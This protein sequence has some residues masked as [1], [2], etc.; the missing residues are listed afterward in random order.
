MEKGYAA[1]LFLVLS[2]VLFSLGFGSQAFAEE[3]FPMGVV[4][5]TLRARI[6]HKA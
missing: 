1:V 6:I 2:F 5:H 4:E 3:K